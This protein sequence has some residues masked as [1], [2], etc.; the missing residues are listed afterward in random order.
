MDARPF[1]HHLDMSDKL[2]PGRAINDRS[3]ING[4]ITGIA[5]GQLV[6][7]P[8]DHRKHFIGDVLLHTEKA[9]R[10]AALPS[11]TKGGGNDVVGHLFRK[12]GRIDD[13][14]IDAACLGD[15]GHYRSIL[16]SQSAIDVARRFRGARECNTRDIWQ[17]HKRRADRA[18]TGQ[19]MQD[20]GRDPGLMQKPHDFHRDQGGLLGRLGKDAIARNKRSGHLA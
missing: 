18:I 3:Y 5:N 1:V 13:Q 19:K 11:R 7:G 16:R 4:D 9:E 8:R 17:G 14:C 15:Q 20:G 12:R 2:F 6:S 10:R